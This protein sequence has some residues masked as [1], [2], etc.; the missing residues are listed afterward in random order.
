MNGNGAPETPET[1]PGGSGLAARAVAFR[2]AS[3]DADAAARLDAF[4]ETGEPQAALHAWFGAELLA[5]AGRAGLR[6][7]V[8]RDIADIDAHVG[9]LIDAILHH[10]RFQKLEAAWRATAWLV[11]TAPAD[12]AA[13]IRLLNVTWADVGRDLSRSA[14][15]DQS[16]LFQK[17]HE[18]AFGI[19][20]GQPFGLLVGDYDVAHMPRGA[21]LQDDVAILR[22]LSKVAAAAFCPF[23]CGASPAMFGVDAFRDMDRRENIAA[24]F[25][26]REY[27]RFVSLQSSEEAR[28]VGIVAPR[29]L[30]RTPYRGRSAGNVGVPYE[31]GAEAAGS[32]GYLWA[33]GAFAFAH[34][35]LRAF[36][37]HNWVAA[38]KGTPENEI[39]GGVVAGLPV[40]AFTTDRPGAAAKIP[41]EVAFSDQQEIQLNS[42]GFTVVR[43]CP[44]TTYSAFYNTPTV[45][46][47]KEYTERAASAN[48]LKSSLLQHVLSVSRFAHYVKVI[49]REWIG[50][51][52]TAE[53]CERKL[54]RWIERY[55]LTDDSAGYSERARRPLRS[56][57]I[58][59][60]DVPG[61]PG[62]Y[63]CTM[64]IQPHFQLDHI[65]SEFQLMTEID[66]V[67]A[68]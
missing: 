47:A 30:V 22:D 4:L 65:V 6:A 9:R 56:A 33:N 57:R 39:S 11:E 53:D 20:G 10:P 8:D 31:E 62:S 41:T 29:V 66:V 58:A 68:A 44:Y 24:T 51:Y 18:D 12:T 2:A 49:A 1:P 50:S 15:F 36:A 13:Q 26:Q 64:H 16:Q 27:E 14:E 35:V 42:L 3:G 59:V 40:D 23:V 48:A 60:R 67:D 17:I 5:K 7:L 34:V 25:R 19:A 21:G 28:F 54:Q 43:P 55:C 45:Q 61:R 37:E 38:V 32:N 63:A 52:K 46:R